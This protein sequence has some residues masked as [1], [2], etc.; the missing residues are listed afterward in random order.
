MGSQ[1]RTRL[2]DWPTTKPQKLPWPPSGSAFQPA[3]VNRAPGRGSGSG[4]GEVGRASGLL[5]VLP[6]PHPQAPRL[7]GFK[8]RVPFRCL[9]E[10]LP[11]C[12]CPS[13]VSSGSSV[14]TV[15][16]VPDLPS[17]CFL[18]SSLCSSHHGQRRPQQVTTAS[19]P[20]LA[21]KSGWT[22]ATEAG[23][24]MRRVRKWKC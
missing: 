11:F 9:C 20:A 17:R 12:P 8:A 19:R 15:S 13:D 18:L 21:G 6:L 4:W 7:A 1:S 22:D 10:S 5:K 2:S 24:K 16:M 14:W 3:G 23:S